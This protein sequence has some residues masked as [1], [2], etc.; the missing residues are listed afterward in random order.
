MLLVQVS[1]LARKECF[2]RFVQ[3]FLLLV[4]EQVQRALIGKQDGPF[5]IHFQH[6]QRCCLHRFAK[7]FII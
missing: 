1:Q 6:R 7:F 3:Q 2:D 4:A 5:L